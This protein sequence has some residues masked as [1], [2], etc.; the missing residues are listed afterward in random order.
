MLNRSRE[1]LPN[2]IKSIAYWLGIVL[3]AAFILVGFFVVGY[4][5]YS[6]KVENVDFLDAVTQLIEISASSFDE[7]A[8]QVSSSPESLAIGLFWL[9]VY[10]GGMSY[11]AQSDREKRILIYV[12]PASA[13]SLLIWVIAA[14]AMF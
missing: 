8:R 2:K 11:V 9:V 10:F 7:I 13:V 1:Q 6:A 4:W 14:Y 5:F 12:F 3:S